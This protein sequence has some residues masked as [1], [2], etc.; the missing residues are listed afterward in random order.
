[1]KEIFAILLTYT[2]EIPKTV[3]TLGQLSSPFS[4]DGSTLLYNVCF[5]SAGP[6]WVVAHIGVDNEKITQK[7]FTE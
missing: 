6:R 2:N 3:D 5:R 1:M 4:L 7:W